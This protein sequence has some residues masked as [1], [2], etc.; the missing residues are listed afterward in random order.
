MEQVSALKTQGNAAYAA[1]AFEDAVSSY[2]KWETRSTLPM[3]GSAVDSSLSCRP[4]TFVLQ[5]P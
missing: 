4:P 1:G 2:T 5:V 3:A